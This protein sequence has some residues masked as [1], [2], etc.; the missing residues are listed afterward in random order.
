MTENTLVAAVDALRGDAFA[1]FQKDYF[2]S[3]QPQT[4]N[5][6]NTSIIKLNDLDTLTK[7]I[8]FLE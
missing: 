5:G 3:K 1:F 2:N 7:D 4:M 8:I 6:E